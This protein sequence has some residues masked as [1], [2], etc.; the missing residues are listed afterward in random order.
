MRFR[1]IVAALDTARPAALGT[2]IGLARALE[3]ELVGLFV[4]DAE[5]LDLA[6][7]PFGEVGYLSPMRR[8]LDV[9]RMERGLRAKARR[10]EQQLGS[11]LAGLPVKW[12]FEVVRGRF[13][14]AV[15]TIAT[16]DDIVVVATPHGATI[17]SGRGADLAQVFRALRSPVLVVRDPLPA[18]GRLAVIVMQ[19]SPDEAARAIAA[20]APS[21]GNS[22]LIA[23][24]GREEEE[25]QPGMHDLE[26]MLA[27]R[28]VRVGTRVL[29]RRTRASLERLLAEEPQAV[30]VVTAGSREARSEL[31]DLLPCPVLVLP[32]LAPDATDERR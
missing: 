14:A 32:E 6:A 23:L 10:I 12:S 19:R 9:G 5:L 27:S 2:A 24:E 22:A 4:E 21:H 1:R 28:G 30:V 11:H 16:A 17:G 20:F 31:L 29:P 8:E 18:A 13:A 25:P 26:R 15:T 7:L 3:A